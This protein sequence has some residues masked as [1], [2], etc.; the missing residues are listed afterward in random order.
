MCDCDIPDELADQMD[1]LE[2]KIARLIAEN[3]AYQRDL[4]AAE[5][6]LEA[7]KERTEKAFRAILKCGIELHR[8]PKRSVAI[9]LITRINIIAHLQHDLPFGDDDV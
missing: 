2:D 4:V 9:N 1:A 7:H 5:G 8:A 6:A 3:D